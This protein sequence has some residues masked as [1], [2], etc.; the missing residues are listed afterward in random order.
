M[1]TITQLW[2]AAVPVILGLMLSGCS[3]APEPPLPVRPLGKAVVIQA[4]LG[5]PPVQAPADNPATAETIA[6]GEKL[7][8]SPLLSADGSLS[9]AS[10]HDPRKAFAD[11]RKVSAGVGG[12]L[13]QR[14]APTV[15]NS[16]YSST[17]FWDGRALSLEAQASGPMMNSLEMAHTLEGVERRCSESPELRAMF[18]AAFGPAPPRRSPVTMARITYAIASYERTLIRGNSPFDRYLYGGRKDALSMAAQ[19]GLALFRDSQKANCAAC[20]IIESQYALLTDNKFHNLGVGMN[21]EGDLTDP[22]R[23]G[24][25]KREGDQGA[26]R[27]PTLRNVAETA[28]YMHDGSLKTLKEVVDFYVGG[29]NANPHRDKLIK[30]LTHLTGQERADLIAFLESLTGAPVH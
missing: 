17:Q 23:Y 4:P 5:L 6:L 1:A 22:G 10:C 11:G 20:H 12:K 28:P 29:G 19:R 2:F 27:T 24:V 15:H 13:G 7:F 8:F 21:P 25:T 9:C 18:E 3:S 30:P 14:N 16:A 26:F